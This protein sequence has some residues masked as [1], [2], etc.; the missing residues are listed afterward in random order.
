MDRHDK[1]CIDVEFQVR[2]V[3]QRFPGKITEC[4]DCI[5]G[6]VKHA[7]SG[8]IVV[9]LGIQQDKRAA[10]AELIGNQ[11]AGIHV[12]SL[13]RGRGRIADQ[14]TGYGEGGYLQVGIFR[15]EIFGIDIRPAV[16]QGHFGAERVRLDLLV[17]K[18]ILG[19]HSGSEVFIEPA[20]LET[21]LIADVHHQVVTCVKFTGNGKRHI[22]G[23]ALHAAQVMLYADDAVVDSGNSRIPGCTVQRVDSGDIGIPQALVRG[24]AVFC[25]TRAQDQTRPVREIQG[26]LAEYRP[27]FAILPGLL[28]PAQAQ[29]GK[30]RR[31]EG[32]A[33]VQRRLQAGAIFIIG[34]VG[35]DN[36]FQELVLW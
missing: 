8:F 18:L 2:R 24:L 7:G 35:A 11:P 16:R 28:V 12:Q 32:L 36:V 26:S 14:E 31:Q 4:R 34:V 3:L 5:T 19:K 23:L 20:G 33:Q 1:V 13:G 6:A 22:V 15:A 25:V 17:L 21:F 27:G 30:K 29:D 9:I 10:H